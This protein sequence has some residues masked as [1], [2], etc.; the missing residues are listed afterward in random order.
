[1]LALL[2]EALHGPQGPLL[3]EGV[4]AVSVSERTPALV[5]CSSAPHV[6]AVCGHRYAA[7]GQAAWASDSAAVVAVMQAAK[8]RRGQLWRQRVSPH[9]DQPG[10][11]AV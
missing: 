11:R 1:M 2:P 6:C 7:L 8:Q 10:G 5:S 4:A 9:A 3:L